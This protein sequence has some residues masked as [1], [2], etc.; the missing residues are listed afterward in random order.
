MR[1]ITIWFMRKIGKCCAISPEGI[2]CSKKYGHNMT[3]P[4]SL[5][6]GW[7][8]NYGYAWGSVFEEEKFRV[9]KTL[10]DVIRER[11]PFIKEK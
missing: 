6:V 2:I 5:H 1:S 8:R 4:M 3:N 10:D 7:N 9:G 11:N